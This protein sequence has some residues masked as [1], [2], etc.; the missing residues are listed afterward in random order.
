VV[1]NDED[2]VIGLDEFLHERFG[3]TAAEPPA[4]ALEPAVRV[5]ARETFLRRWLPAPLVRRLDAGFARSNA[6]HPDTARAL[7]AIV[8]AARPTIV[9]E[10]GT[11]WGF[12]TAILAAAVQEVHGTAVH[13]FDRYPKAGAHLAPALRPWVVMH[14]GR[15]S[16][17]AMPPV[18][19]TVTP[20]VFFQDSR[21]DYDGVR[22]ELQ[23]VAPRMPAHGL[24]LFHDW[25][26]AQVRRAA[27]DQLVGW[28]L[29]RIAGADPQQLGV[30]WRDPRDGAG[31]S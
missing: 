19:A 20:D 3:A 26:D 30:A 28:E 21:H 12:S 13:T 29:S 24:I 27:R 6:V 23:I 11:Y 15:P 5:L 4:D 18:L 10:T 1:V 8:R 31:A 7:F 2:R 16:V 22:D 9:F 25:V 14:R 17:E